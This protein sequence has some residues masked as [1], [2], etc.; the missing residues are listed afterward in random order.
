M[1]ALCT[2]DDRKHRLRA[3][4]DETDVA[5]VAV[6][7]PTIEGTSAT[8]EEFLRHSKDDEEVDPETQEQEDA[9]QP[10]AGVVV[11]RS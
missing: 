3:L 4:V 6:G 7:C 9:K 2:G 1:I 10:A 5:A 11:K 8:S